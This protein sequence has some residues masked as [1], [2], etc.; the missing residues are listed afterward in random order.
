MKSK[1]KGCT[2]ENITNYALKQAINFIQFIFILKSQY[3]V[4]S[5]VI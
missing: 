3:T 5:M 1:E 2:L 4:L